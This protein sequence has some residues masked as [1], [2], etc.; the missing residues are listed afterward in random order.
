MSN[1]DL[2]L[3][4]SGPIATVTFNRPDKANALGIDWLSRMIEFF[5]Q[6]ERDNGV[7]CVLI[8]GNGKH[9]QA[10]ADVSQLKETLKETR[11]HKRLSWFRETIGQGNELV[12]A[13]MHL[14]K[15]VVASVQGGVVGGGLSIAGAADLVIAADDAFF[16]QGQIINGYSLDG[17]PSYLLPRQIGYRKAMEWALLGTKVS[18][19][20]AE[21]L[22]FVNFVVPRNDLESET[23]SL[24][25]KL[26]KGPTKA[27]GT[28]KMLMLRT[29]QNGP[30]EQGGLEI[31]LYMDI[32][33]SEDWAEGTHA[34]LERREPVYKGG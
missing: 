10:G 29:W 12:R 14:S 8:R 6:I 23:K 22:G 7:R 21:R 31:D 24:M 11:L 9:F 19:Q 16:C 4:T 34:F 32:A 26:A 20:D 30:D 33:A 13:I 5:R 27:Y 2:L 28:N 25:N 1:T 18:A 17:M 3:D 15:P